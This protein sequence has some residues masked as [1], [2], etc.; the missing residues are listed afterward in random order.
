MPPYR[1]EDKVAALD[2]LL[3]ANDDIALAATQ[4]G[5]SP[6]S[7]RAWARDSDALRRA[8]QE[9][10]SRQAAHK[11]ARAQLALADKTLE[12]I[13]AM[14]S[15]RI[16]AAPLNQLSSALGA[17]VDRYLRIAGDMPQAE[18]VVRFE[19][20]QPDGRFSP[21]PPWSGENPDSAAALQSGGLWAPL[22]QDGAGQNGAHRAHDAARP[23]D[24]VAGADLRYGGAGLAGPEDESDERI[25]YQ[26]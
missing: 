13:T 16:A 22:R 11:M 18:Q 4:S 8:H 21:A 15:D 23:A 20:Q 6:K 25:W 9:E 2:A 1:L 17:V 24:V 14:D 3:A 7:L 12:L 26:D 10:M 5:V 19:F